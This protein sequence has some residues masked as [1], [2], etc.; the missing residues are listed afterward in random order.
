MIAELWH[1]VPD[2]VAFDVDG[3]LYVAHYTPDRIDRIAPDGTVDVLVEDWEAIHLN[4]PTNVAF[5][6]P[7]LSLLVAACVGEEF[8]AI[9][10]LGI[11]GQPLRRPI[12][13]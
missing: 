11:R 10:D 2:G 3:N 9:A 13:G 8:L 4:A 6:G 12:F 1:T 7:D 5:A